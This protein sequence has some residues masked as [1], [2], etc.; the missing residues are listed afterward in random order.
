MN[1]MVERSIPARRSIG[2]VQCLKLG[3]IPE[4]WHGPGNLAHGLLSLVSPP[5]AQRSSSFSGKHAGSPLV[6]WFPP[7]YVLL[8]YRL[9]FSPTLRESQ[10]GSGGFSRLVSLTIHLSPGNFGN[11]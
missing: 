9:R 2:S 6:S 8:C 3:E 4:P 11:A 1:R 10:V 5:V 7:Q